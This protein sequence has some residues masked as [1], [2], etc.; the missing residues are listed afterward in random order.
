MQ[1]KTHRLVSH[2]ALW[3]CGGGLARVFGGK[4]E[5]N[6]VPTGRKSKKE[7]QGKPIEN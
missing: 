7:E 2:F 1:P 4:L 5:L 6:K 3:L